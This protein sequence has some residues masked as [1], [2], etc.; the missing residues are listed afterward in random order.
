MASLGAPKPLEVFEADRAREAA[1][2][3]IRSPGSPPA[4]SASGLINA[5]PRR[6]SSC[7]GHYWGLGGPQ[8]SE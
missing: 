5:K 7:W 2:Q 8:P 1:A 3:S 6:R 4:C